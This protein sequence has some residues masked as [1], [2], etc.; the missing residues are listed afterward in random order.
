MVI[1]AITNGSVFDGESRH[2]G[3]AVLLESGS[4]SALVPDTEIPRAA[5]VFDLQGG[6]LAPGF[7]DLQV[8]G[9]GGVLFNQAPTVETIRRIGR[10]HRAFGTTGFLPTLITSDYATMRTAIA[11]VADA[12]AQGVPGLLGIHLEGPFLNRRRAGIHQQEVICQPDEE[13]FEILTSLDSGVT[14]VT[15]APE[16]A[17]TGLISRLSA[18]G[19]L[20]SAG[21]TEASYQEIREALQAGLSGFTHLYNAM[22]PMTSREPGVVGA[23]LE[24]EDSWFGIIADG[25]HSHP[26]SFKVAVRAKPPGGAVL[27]TDA[28]ATVGSDQDSFELDGRSIR[29]EAG[30]CTD[31]NGT[32]AGSHLDMLSA[33]ENASRFADIDR[34]EA[35]RMASLY[36]A[37]VLGLDTQLGRVRRGQRANLLAL[38]RERRLLATWIDGECQPAGIS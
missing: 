11:A 37:R 3:M 15:L 35:M 18:T 14:L 27:V 25:H 38:D 17:G 9:G 21:H 5:E 31:D 2:S 1:K 26:A 30:R 8:N 4:V 7:I 22:T 29:L 12:M 16:V 32:L 13:G 24:D 36:P 34:F 20:V 10:A 23:A 28:M 19:V 33:V 6:L